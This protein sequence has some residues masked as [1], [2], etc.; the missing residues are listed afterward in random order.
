MWTNSGVYPN[1]T[2]ITSKT[3]VKRVRIQIKPDRNDNYKFLTSTMTVSLL[4]D[5]KTKPQAISTTSK[6]ISDIGA[7]QKYDSEF[8]DL[9]SDSELS[10][11]PA[12]NYHGNRKI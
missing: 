2:I 12:P 10:L 4:K 1:K 8:G 9:G 3:N 5:V 7:D 11:L 6:A